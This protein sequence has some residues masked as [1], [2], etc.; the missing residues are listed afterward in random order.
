MG[1][2]LPLPIINGTSKSLLIKNNNIQFSLIQGYRK[3]MEDFYSYYIDN[4]YLYLALFDGHG[5]SYVSSYLHNNFLKYLAKSI[6]SYNIDSYKSIDLLYNDIGKVIKNVYIEIDKLIYD[7]ID[8]SKSQGSTVVSTI[9]TNNYIIFSHCGDSPVSAYNGKNIIYKSIDHKPIN[10]KERDRII[11]SGHKII[12]NRIDGIIDIS[13]CL[14]DFKFKGL[15]SAIIPIPVVKIIKKDTC[16]FF[17]LMTDGITNFISIS[18]ICNYIEY[19]LQISQDISSIC[20]SILMRAIYNESS[21]NISI[22]LTVIQK[23]MI[24]DTLKN[25]Y[26]NF[27]KHVN[28][29]VVNEIKKKPQIYLNKDPKIIRILKLIKSLD[30]KSF[31]FSLAYEFRLI[32]DILDKH[33]IF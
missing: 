29:I 13:R 31:K 22:C 18:E 6:K 10:K 11:K 26:D 33:E 7:N 2:L 8:F 32:S 20:D 19:K 5:G 12:N 27:I 4:K 24:N 23:Y 9:I 25:E 16:K 17:I 28:K 21:D 14:G 15:K 1:N 3:T 30:S